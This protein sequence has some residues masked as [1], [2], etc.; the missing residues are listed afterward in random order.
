MKY[1]FWDYIKRIEKYDIRQIGNL[2]KLFGHLMASSDCG[3]EFLKVVDFG[4]SIE[5]LSKPVQLLLFI[6]LDSIFTQ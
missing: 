4:E 3:I 5:E 1:T 6:I 2:A